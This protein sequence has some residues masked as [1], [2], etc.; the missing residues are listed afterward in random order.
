MFEQKKKKGETM[1]RA[2]DFSLKKLIKGTIQD[3]VGLSPYEKNILEFLKI[4]KDKRA[5]K[6]CKKKLGN[7]SRAKKKK[8]QLNT[9]LRNKSIVN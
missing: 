1:R 4:G 5:N 7:I 8:E 9:F 3:V 6:L 2:S